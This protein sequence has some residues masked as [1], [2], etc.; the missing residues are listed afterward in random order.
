MT[1]VVR[2]RLFAVVPAA[3]TSR[4]MGRPKLLL[5]LGNATA[6]S[7]MLAAL[8]RQ[9]IAATVVIVR[10][11]DEPLRAA[12]AESGATPLQPETPPPEMRD[13]VEYGLRYLTQHFQPQPDDG[14]LLIPAD[15]PLLEPAVMDQVIAA[16]QASPEKIII[17]VYQKKRGHPTVF[18]FRLA[19]D[20]FALAANEGLNSLLARRADEIEPIEVASFSVV[21][22]LDTPDDYARLKAEFERR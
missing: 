8:A 21:A 12:V 1:H 15:H 9:E 3:G 5:P 4:R 22:D 13:S 14:W 17:P 19:P 10:S 16:W 11:D 18:P 20:V 2:R 6:I 7:T